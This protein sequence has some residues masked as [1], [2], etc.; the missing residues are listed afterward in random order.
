MQFGEELKIT[1]ISV[2]IFFI[3]EDFE[4]KKKVE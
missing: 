4:K 1:L 2:K 3:G